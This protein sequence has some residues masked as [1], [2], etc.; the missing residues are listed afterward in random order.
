MNKLF[1]LGCVFGVWLLA[2][3]G[4]ESDSTKQLNTK[5]AKQS[6]L[7]N[8][9]FRIQ[10]MPYYNLL[11]ELVL[12]EAMLKQHGL[13]QY[14]ASYFLRDTDQ[15]AYKTTFTNLNPRV[16][17]LSFY[18]VQKR[19]G[20][21][22]TVIKQRTTELSS[23]QE[24]SQRIVHAAGGKQNQFEVKTTYDDAHRIT[25]KEQHNAS[26]QRNEIERYTYEGDKLMRKEL[27]GLG[28][29][30]FMYNHDGKEIQYSLN[31]T[32]GDTIRSSYTTYA[33]NKVQVNFNKGG[34]DQF[35]YFY[36]DDRLTQVIWSDHGK[37]LVQFA[38]EYDE[39]GILK[40]RITKSSIP[41]FP[42]NITR[43]E[44]Q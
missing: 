10:P 29:E 17:E 21:Y 16:G 34:R 2:S 37:T 32:N 7:T 35:E 23:S 25:L 39:K 36:Q 33:P 8:T 41:A 6:S 5:Q 3:C 20:F 18:L 28:E 13:T 43:Y 19:N 38:F 12:D 15:E 11:S 31:K 1:L 22:D 44:F 14:K 40:N 26:N 27:V 9:A 4:N 30:R 24:K 42:S